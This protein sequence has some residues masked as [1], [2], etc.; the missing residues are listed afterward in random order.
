M[1]I[2]LSIGN[3]LPDHALQLLHLARDISVTSYNAYSGFQVGA[4]VQTSSGG[5]Y[6]G[7]FMENASYGMTVCAEATAVLTC[8]SAG[9]RDI[10]TIAIVGGD[11][12][13]EGPSAA[14]TPCGR[15]RQILWEI[16]SINRRDVEVYCAD[17]TLTNILLTTS[18]ELLPYAW[19]P[20]W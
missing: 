2:S 7:S 13:N 6:S 1:A 18:R 17:L 10:V 11:P 4:T 8:N 19:G 12:T 14:C 15:C 9:H 16:A 3:G 20:Q 5:Q